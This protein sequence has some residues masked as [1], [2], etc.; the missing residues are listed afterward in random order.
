MLDRI[1]KLAYISEKKTSMELQRLAHLFIVSSDIFTLQCMVLDEHI[2][3][4]LQGQVCNLLY[5]V[6]FV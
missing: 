3:C 4:V 5:T 1:S 2:L 6:F